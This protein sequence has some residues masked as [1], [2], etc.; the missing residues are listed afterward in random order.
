LPTNPPIPVGTG[1]HLVVKVSSSKIATPQAG[2]SAPSV[3]VINPYTPGNN[4]PG[5]DPVVNKYIGI[6][7]VDSNNKVVKFTLIVLGKGDV[8]PQPEA[9]PELY[10][11][12]VPEPGTDPDTTKLPTNPPIPVGTGN[13]LVVKVSSS[14]IATPKAGD[15]APSVG[16]INP[17]TPGN[18]I[19][20]V[21]PVVNKYIGI[22]E[23]DSNNKVVKFTLI[24]LGKGDV[25][26][27]P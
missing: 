8:R 26:P 9:A 3:G 27:Q 13:H 20:G 1:N 10:P 19:P 16:V 4:I 15:L 23:V 6:Y 12:P 17:Y 11:T 5:V 21:D 7:E 22:Y 24:V 18:N 2:D 25:R 14:K